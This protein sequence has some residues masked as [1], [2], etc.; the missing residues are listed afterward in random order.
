MKQYSQ[1]EHLSFDDIL[2]VPQHSDI[3]SRRD[4]SLAT[5]LGNGLEL[6]IPVI[7]APMDTVC[8]W[9]MV[10]AMDRLGGMGILHRYMSIEQQVAM[11][12]M[13]QAQS[14][15]K[16][17]GGSVGARGAFVEEA[18]KLVHA[19]ANV[20]LIDVANGHNQNAINAVSSLRKE[21]GEKIHIMA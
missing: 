6:S 9:Q 20:I 14:G 16:N 1:T 15:V 18:Q 13:S 19:G 3:E 7:A 11:L 4:V 21:L 17:I 8:E 2:L 5:G 10:E 12:K